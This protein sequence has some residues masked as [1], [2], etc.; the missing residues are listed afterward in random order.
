[1]SRVGKKPIKIPD[2]TKI[3]YSEKFLVV[4]GDKGKLSQAIHP[5][6]DLSIDRWRHEC[7]NG[8][9][10]SYQPGIAGAYPKS[11]GQHDYRC[12]QGV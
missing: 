4:E 10:R 7:N 8:N 2:K 3:S 11:G 12:E 5:A 6:I 1:M 9:R